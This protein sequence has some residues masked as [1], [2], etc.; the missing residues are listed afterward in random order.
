MNKN[1]IV[2]MHNYICPKNCISQIWAEMLR[3]P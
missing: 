1:I 2:N 3:D